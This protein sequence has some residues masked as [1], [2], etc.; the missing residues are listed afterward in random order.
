MAY[1][2]APY[3]I[4]GVI[5]YQGESDVH[6]AWEYRALFQAMIHSWRKAWG[7]DDLPFIYAQLPPIGK[8]AVNPGDDVNARD[9]WAELREAQA[10]A[11]ALPNTGMAVLIDSDEA[12][13]IHPLNK[14]WAAERFARVARAVA[15][16]EGIEH[17]GPVYD[18]MKIEGGRI[19]ITFKHTGGGLVAKDSENGELRRFAI[20]GEDR[21]FV[22]ANAV[23]EGD[24][25]LVWNDQAPNPVAVRYAW[26]GNPDGCNLF[27]KAGLP[28]PP[29]R[30]D[31]W[32][33]RTT[34]RKF[35]F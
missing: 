31:D 26:A 13:T 4:R 18:A 20:A 12:R 6:N 5:W 10:M 11:L 22:W 33:E 27:N 32:P 34:G 30:T 23:I 21:N 35:P 3:G 15:Y 9:S 8:A 19:R 17:S 29:F 25:V 14:Q 2:V 24:T 1:P 7:R 16:G 28:A